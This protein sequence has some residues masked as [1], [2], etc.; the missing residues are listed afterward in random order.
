MWYLTYRVIT[1]CHKSH[2]PAS[3][4]QGM[5]FVGPVYILH[6]HTTVIYDNS[7]FHNEGSDAG[8]FNV[9]S[10]VAYFCIDWERRG[11]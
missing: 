8:I 2:D 9:N 5:A 11:I 3:I 6:S 4:Y 7:V 10:N 1:V